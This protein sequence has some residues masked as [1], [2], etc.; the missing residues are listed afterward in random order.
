MGNKFTLSAAIK[1][2]GDLVMLDD[3]GHISYAHL[4]A[5]PECERFEFNSVFARINIGVILECHV[6][7]YEALSSYKIITNNGNIGWIPSRHIDQVQSV[8]L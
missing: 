1:K 8:V 7:T 2:P 3:R 6:R 5:D 4:Y